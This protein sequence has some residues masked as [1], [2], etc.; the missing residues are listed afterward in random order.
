MIAPVYT[1]LRPDTVEL[2]LAHS[3]EYFRPAVRPAVRLWGEHLFLLW[4]ERQGVQGEPP[5]ELRLRAAFG[6][7]GPEA[8]APVAS[9][10]EGRL[11][12]RVE[13][14]VGRC[15]VGDLRLINPVFVQDGWYRCVVDLVEQGLPEDRIREELAFLESATSRMSS[16]AAAE[17]VRSTAPD[18][19]DGVVAHFGHTFRAYAESWRPFVPGSSNGEELLEVVYP[20]EAVRSITVERD[21]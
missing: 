19:L 15:A 13:V 21:S 12:C 2:F 16:A 3:A 18:V 8:P 7:T 11:R 10:H 9:A 4:S 5:F 14:D 17:A 6:W 20:S 1:W